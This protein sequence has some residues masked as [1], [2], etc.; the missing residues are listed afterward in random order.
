MPGSEGHPH[1]DHRDLR[2]SC[3]ADRSGQA[4]EEV[5]RCGEA[6]DDAPL[7]VHDQQGAVCR[8]AVIGG[9]GY[10]TAWVPEPAI[11]SVGPGF[12]ARI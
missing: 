5:T 10:P 1:E 9:H 8:G 11:R 12:T 3:R 6:L 7:D 4:A 2:S